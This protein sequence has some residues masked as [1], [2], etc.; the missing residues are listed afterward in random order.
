ML[1]NTFNFN[2]PVNTVGILSDNSKIIL[3]SDDF[4]LKIW[5]KCTLSGCYRCKYIIKYFL[6]FSLF[7]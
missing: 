4:K 1:I 5:T 3:G 6:N 7:F 2:N